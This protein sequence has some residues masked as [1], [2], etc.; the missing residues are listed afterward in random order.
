MIWAWGRAASNPVV[1]VSIQTRL[2]TAVQYRGGADQWTAK[3]LTQRRKSGRWRGYYPEME[4]HY[5][6]WQDVFTKIEQEAV[7]GG[8]PKV[9]G[10]PRGGAIVAGL[11]QALGRGQAVENADAAEMFVDDIYDSGGTQKR[12]EAVYGRKPWWFVIDKRKAEEKK[13]G[14]IVF[15]WENPVEEAV[16]ALV[17]IGGPI[18]QA[19]ALT[20]IA[21]E[22]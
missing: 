20:G 5:L 14:W 13:L 1:S 21:G 16:E 10:P 18:T 22:G 19:N 7:F 8:R 11:I 4:L 17:H 9:W 12:V 15:P 3:G 6:S 2:A